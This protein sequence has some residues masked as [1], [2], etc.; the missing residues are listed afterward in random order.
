MKNMLKMALAVIALGFAANVYSEVRTYGGIYCRYGNKFQ[1]VQIPCSNAFDALSGKCYTTKMIFG[2][3]P[4]NCP[5]MN[6]VSANGCDQYT[7]ACN[8]AVPAY[9]GPIKLGASPAA[10]KRAVTSG[11]R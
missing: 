4:D 11:P 2:I 7:G 10:A 3:F 9:T 8:Y 1:Q 5:P 6:G